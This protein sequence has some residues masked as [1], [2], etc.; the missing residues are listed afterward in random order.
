MSY[1]SSFPLSISED[2]TILVFASLII[3]RV[4][5]SSLHHILP[6][7]RSLNSAPIV[8]IEVIKVEFHVVF[9]RESTLNV[10]FRL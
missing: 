9:L 2:A 3:P 6:L 1:P 7:I 4:H 8:V 10:M 5:S